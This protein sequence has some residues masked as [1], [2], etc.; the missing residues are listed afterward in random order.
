[1]SLRELKARCQQGCVPSRSSGGRIPS[2]FRLLRLPAFLGLWL[3]SPPP[4]LPSSHLLQF[5]SLSYKD[6]CEYTGP[7]PI[8]LDHLPTSRS[9]LQSPLFPCRVTHSQALGFIRTWT[10]LGDCYS[11][12]HTLCQSSGYH[13]LPCF[14][15]Y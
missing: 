3:H 4:L 10:S 12:D 14:L 11:A 1:M 15:E 7:M 8:T 5:S 9:H 2:V 6:L 13:N